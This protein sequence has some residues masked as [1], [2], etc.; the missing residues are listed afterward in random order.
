MHR[1]MAETLDRALG[2][3]PGRSRPA[4]ATSGSAARPRWPMIVLVSPK[5]WTGPK[6]VDG[7]PV[8]GTWRAHQVPLDKIREN[9]EHLRSSRP[10]CEATGPGSS[11]TS[12]AA[13]GRSSASSRRRESGGWGRIRTR[14]AESCFAISHLPDFRA[15]AVEVPKPG[16]S[17]PRRR[18]SGPIPARRPR[19]KRR[20]RATSGSSRPTRP[21]RTAGTPSSTSRIACRSRR[22]CR[23][24]STSRPTDA[25]SRCS[26]STSAKA[27]SRA[28]SSRA[29]TASSR[30][31]RRSSTSSTR[32]STSTRNG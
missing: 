7:K 11:S 31:T 9:P 10:G 27:G 6:S 3:H 12:A 25:S 1:L 2:R 8:E 16:A 21:R 4:R 22:S 17:T 24:T 28:I 13:S 15:Y 32:C 14:T 23:P 18:A 29:G 30:A 20:T 26:P 19:A 5:G